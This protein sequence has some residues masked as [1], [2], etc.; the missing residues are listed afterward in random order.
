MAL[1]ASAAPAACIADE[2][3]PALDASPSDAPLT[4]ITPKTASRT[5]AGLVGA[6]SMDEDSTL[7][8]RSLDG[9]FGTASEPSSPAAAFTPFGM[10]PTPRNITTRYAKQFPG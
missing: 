4:P 5:P 7:E 8:P 10:P 6:P 2:D 3:S 9:I 1:S